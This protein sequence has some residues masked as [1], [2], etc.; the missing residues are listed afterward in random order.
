MQALEEKTESEETTEGFI[1][2]GGE[3]HD[4][5]LPFVITGL[6]RRGDV[7]RMAFLS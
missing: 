7:A 6:A 4:G 5:V 3:G 2:G 1:G